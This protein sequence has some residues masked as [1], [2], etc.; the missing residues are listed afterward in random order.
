MKKMLVTTWYGTFILEGPEIVDKKLFPRDLEEIVS[1]LIELRRGAILPEEKELR[2]KHEGEIVVGERRLLGLKET[3][4]G[5]VPNLNDS[6]ESYGF[7]KRF[8]RD[9]VLEFSRRLTSEKAAKDRYLA[10]TIAAYD[11]IVKIINL[12][13]ERLREWHGIHFPELSSEVSDH[14]KYAEIVE[15]YGDYETIKRELSEFSEIQTSG[16]PIGR[17][18]IEAIREFARYL[19]KGFELRDRLIKYI[20]DFVSREAPNL[21]YLLG[22]SLA[23]RLIAAAGGLEKL[24]KM[25]ASSIQVLGAEKALF[26]HLRKGAKPPKHGLIFMY[27]A[28][29]GS[30]KWQRGKIARALATKIAIAAKADAFT[31]QFI[32]EK[33]KEDLEKRINEIKEKYKNPPRR[34]KKRKRGRRVRR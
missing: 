33:L 19:L 27:P 26:R 23:A 25:P 6:F 1:R 22:P 10:Q 15:K 5:E 34:K 7:T 32:A 24:A 12:L 8:F 28:I 31:G 16:S 4:L 13:A 18:D 20:E 21:T 9:V 30:P 3:K 2:E 29:H 14:K 11:D 17:E